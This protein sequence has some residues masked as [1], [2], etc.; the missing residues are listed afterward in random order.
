MIKLQD[1]YTKKNDDISNAPV[2]RFIDSII[3]KAIE[4]RAS[5]IHIEPYN[6]YTKIRFRVDGSLHEVVKISKQT[7]PAIITRIKIISN[8]NIAEKRLPQDGR[9]VFILDKKEYDLRISI[10]PTVFGEKVVIRILDRNNF[11][12]P[13]VKLGFDEEDAKSLHQIINQPH[14]IILLTGPTGSGKSTTLYSLL[15]ELN[16]QS[17]SIITIEDPVEYIMEGISQIQVNLKT[18]FTF[19]EGLRSILRQDPDILMVG[20]IRDAET[21]RIAVRAAI[22]GHLVF[23]TLHTNDAP[24][25]ITRLIDMGVEPFLLPSS[26]IASIAQRLVRKICLNCMYEYNASENEKGI[27]GI[28]K[29]SDLKLYRGRGCS[30]CNNTGYY[31]RTGVYEIMVIN[32]EYRSAIINNNGCDEIKQINKRLGMKTLKDSCAKLVIQG[33]TTMDEL[34]KIT[35]AN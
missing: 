27:L 9:Y 11:L 34:L 5:D 20:E 12:L 6:D 21:A 24:S 10:I 23:S 2:V 30:Q 16:V 14:G 18:G 28:S 8:L 19:A 15:N 22:T 1:T 4:E 25:T 32:D 7:M 17:K 3:S 35:Y 29:S 33:I 31:S 13:M 26:I